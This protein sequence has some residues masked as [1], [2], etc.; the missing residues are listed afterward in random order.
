MKFYQRVSL[1]EA[2]Q[3][4]GRIFS[5]PKVIPKAIL[6]L[7]N[8][9]ICSIYGLW[10][11]IYGSAGSKIE[12]EHG[13][14]FFPGCFKLVCGGMSMLMLITEPASSLLRE[15]KEVQV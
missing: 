7:R 6:A 1:V 10:C 12:V 4:N 8:L 14:I 15:E 13:E 2:R 11:S 9:L 5:T 3:E